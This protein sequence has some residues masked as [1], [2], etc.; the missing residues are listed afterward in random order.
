MAR[1]FLSGLTWG[2]FAG[3][4]GVTVMSLL[5][6]LA[7]APDVAVDVPD[8]A[9]QVTPEAGQGASIDG[10]GRDADL[11]GAQPTVPEAGQ[12]PD[13]V[14][15]LD[16]QPSPLPQV[17]GDGSAL[18]GPTETGNAGQ[19]DIAT[20]TPVTPGT[21]A[22]GP[23]APASET[24]LSI[25]TEPAQPIAPDVGQTEAGFPSTPP[26]PAD[27]PNV[28]TAQDSPPT[29][30]PIQTTDPTAP[31][32]S[33]LTPSQP[34]APPTPSVNRGVAAV[35][36]TG[37]DDATQPRRLTV[38]TPVRPLTERPGIQPDGADGDDAN[39][40]LL[41]PMQAYALPFDNPEDKPMM[42][43]VLIDGKDAL[44][45]EAL[46]GFPYPLTMAVDPT[47][48]D[49]AERMEKHRAAGFEI[50]MLIDM[51]STATAQDA[52]VMLAAGFDAVPKSVAVLEGVSTGIQGNRA[53]SDQVTA[54]T[55]D[56]GRGL[57]TQDNGLNTAQKLAARAGVPSSV[58]FRDFDGAGQTPTVMRRFL[59]QAAFRARQDGAVIMLGRLRPDTISAL[60]LWGLQDR[61]AR[62]S[63]AP[64]SAVL[65]RTMDEAG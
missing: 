11:A 25:S 58:V 51:P 56:S 2:S 8:S 50:V 59:D 7:Q 26:V 64:V 44:G 38:G 14:S 13:D 4:G 16:T 47:L 53:L 20:D 17:G 32:V 19:I 33:S 24:E 46:D 29:T 34:S 23:S 18:S 12:G 63:L 37:V 6:P 9:G 45:A 10:A 54:I 40:Q 55:A 57:I 36:Q 60:L 49:A 39:F 28:A 48:P 27:A 43:I 65:K 1:G 62:V 52:E 15:D 22:P 35:P 61:A 41:P 5:T 31:D 30:P 21:P 42:S 3:I